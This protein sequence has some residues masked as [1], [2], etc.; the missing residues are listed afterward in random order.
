MKINVKH[1]YIILIILA[2]IGILISTE[3]SIVYFKANFTSSAPSF[4]SVNQ[5]ID[6]DGVAKTEFSRF[7][8]VPLSLWGFMFYSLVLF[9]SSVKFLQKKFPSDDFL[10]LFKNPLSY[11]YVFSFFSVL[12]S[13]VL[14]YISSQIIH[15]MCIFCYMLY[16]LNALI[17]IF[18]STGDKFLNYFKNTINDFSNAVK[19]PFYAFLLSMVIIGSGIGLFLINYYGVFMSFDAVIMGFEYRNPEHKGN[20]LGN[21]SGAI[22]LH[23]YTDFQCP[24]CKISNMMVNKAADE[25]ENVFV[26]HHEFPLDKTCNK[27][28]VETVHKKSG[29]IAKYSIAAANQGKSWEFT[30]LLFDRQ[31]GLPKEENIL[32]V[33]KEVGLNIDQ[34][35]KDAYN[36]ETE[37]FLMEEIDAAIRNKIE[38]TP[39]Y[40]IGMN[41]YDGLMS[42]N[43]LKKTLIEAGGKLKK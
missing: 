34:L 33:A 10:A 5:Y 36:P 16:F 2:I 11:I 27:Y 4:C 41:N 35:K 25:F 17:F 3:L 42:Y 19:K 21:P 31:K 32:K 14:A 20:I 12:G 30:N 26:V 22:I 23:E 40:R 1:Q 37:K 24:Y 43:E 18:S 7:L 8:G 9:L 38:V 28:I 29:V 6:C 15:K 39:S 13:L